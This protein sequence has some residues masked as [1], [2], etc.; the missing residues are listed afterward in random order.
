VT[1]SLNAILAFIAIRQPTLC[2]VL[3]R[4]APSNIPKLHEQCES[5]PL[6]D[7]FALDVDVSY[8]TRWILHRFYDSSRLVFRSVW[9]RFAFSACNKLMCLK[10]VANVI[11]SMTLVKFSVTPSI[12]TSRIG[13]RVDVSAGC[14]CSGVFWITMRWRGTELCL[15]S[16]HHSCSSPILPGKSLF[17]IF[18]QSARVFP[19]KIDSSIPSMPFSVSSLQIIAAATEVKVIPSP[20]SAATSAPGISA[21][22]THLLTMN[23]IAQTWC[24]RNFVL[25]RLELN[26][27]GLEN[28]HQ[29]IDKSGEH[30]AAWMPPQ[31]T[32]VQICCW[33][34]W[35]QYSILNWY[36]LDRG[37]PCHPL[38]PEPLLHLGLSY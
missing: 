7:G 21:S 28:G 27:C 6:L 18:T 12:V 19:Y 10:S 15:S 22:Q 29:L 31:D 23:Q 30:S 2:F 4:W 24:A 16:G 26:T 9:V 14:P 25:G 11:W 37:P 20:I 13:C 1:W 32:C 3:Y 35:E 5:W 17:T 36:F 8:N 38:A 33:L 34:W